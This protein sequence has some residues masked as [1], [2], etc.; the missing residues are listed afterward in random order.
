M[1]PIKVEFMPKFSVSGIWKRW[2]ESY[3]SKSSKSDDAITVFT[4]V[5][6]VFMLKLHFFFYVI[7]PSCLDFKFDM[8]AKAYQT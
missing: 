2:R 4:G 8:H 6:A 1:F 3:P 7:R 5:S